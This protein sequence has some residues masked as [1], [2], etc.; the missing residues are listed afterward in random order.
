MSYYYR[1]GKERNYDTDTV[2]Q[3]SDS[4]SDLHSLFLAGP[5]GEVINLSEL[6]LLQLSTK[7]NNS[8]SLGH[9]D[10]SLF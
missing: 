8:V 6:Q 7:V 2:I 1:R 9:S 5:F 4:E 3:S 10:D